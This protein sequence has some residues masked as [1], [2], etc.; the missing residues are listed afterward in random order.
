MNDPAARAL[1]RKIAFHRAQKGWSQREFGALID[2]SE[3]WVSQV[4]R[5]V[6]QID[7]MTVLRSV[8]DVLEVPLG[9]LASD[10]PIVVAATQRS[11]PAISLRLLL[12]E[13]LRLA[14]AID[15]AP[16]DLDLD[17][18]RAD[19]ERA[20]L[21]AHQSS[22]GELIPLLVEL[23]PLLEAVTRG[24]RGTQQKSAFVILA[25]AYH[26]CAAA[27][28]K[29]G[30][31]P[32]AW[33]AADRAIAAGDR[34]GDRLLMA[35]GAFRLTLVFQTERQYDQAERTALSAVNALQVLVADG[36]LAAVAIQG[37][38]RLQLAIAAARQNEAEAAYSYLRQAR[39]AA[40]RLGEDRN[41][42]NTEFGPTN[43]SLHEVAVA[44]DLGDAGAALRVAASIDSSRLSPERQ[45]RLLMDVARA[46]LQR[47]HVEGAIQALLSA[48]K[49]S[50]EQ[51]R[52]HRLV[53][54]LLHDLARA[55]HGS[56]PRL[57][58]LNE[59]LRSNPY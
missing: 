24:T 19:A 31:V 2:R 45:G 55:G 59:R 52:R 8:A 27:L 15:A 42:Y 21:L 23:V 33:V 41:D 56:D 12:S 26:A 1:G 32:A 6:R 39:Q 54:D 17:L 25:K 46:N 9:E 57:V 48:E 10:T 3:T 5:G 18:L 44:I 43:V 30:E 38:L 29:L 20:W 4:E 28:S 11:E 47:R 7:R 53:R 14:L 16:E 49:V 22:Y 51:V 58:G 35:E 40:D 34:A 50:P 13:S 36:V 37:A